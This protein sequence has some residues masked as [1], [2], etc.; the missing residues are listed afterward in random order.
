MTQAWS[1]YGDFNSPLFLEERFGGQ[2]VTDGETL[3][4][5]QTCDAACLTDMKSMG[6]FYTWTN[7]HVW[8]NT[9]GAL[10]N[11]QWITQYGNVTTRFQENYFSYYSLILLEFSNA[12]GHERKPFRFLNVLTE[13]KGSMYIVTEAWKLKVKGSGMFRVWQ[14]LKHCKELLKQLKD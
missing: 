1:V 6:R 7:K 12:N 9:D 8:R 10:C 3:D 11:K 2:L 4:F 5:R 14:K 13:N